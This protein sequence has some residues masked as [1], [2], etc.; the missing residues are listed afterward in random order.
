MDWLKTT[1][2]EWVTNFDFLGFGLDLHRKL[3]KN[4]KKHF[5]QVEK[6]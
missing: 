5:N 1:H 2:M 6:D 4:F 3:D